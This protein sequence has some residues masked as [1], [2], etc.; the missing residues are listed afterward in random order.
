MR[1]K[2]TTLVLIALVLL[3]AVPVSSAD[4]GCPPAFHAHSEGD[5]H[6]DGHQHAGLAMDAVDRNGNGVICVKHVGADGGIHVHIDDF[7]P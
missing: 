6:G 7:L 5:M 1:R 4:P 2:L 3:L